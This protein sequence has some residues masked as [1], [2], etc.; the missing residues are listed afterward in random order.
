M[1][2]AAVPAMSLARARTQGWLL[3]ALIA[4]SPAVG[5]GHPEIALALMLGYVLGLAADWRVS[6][7]T[8]YVLFVA[9]VVLVPAQYRLGAR[10]PIDMRVD[11]LVLLM[12]LAGWAFGLFQTLPEILTPEAKRLRAPLLGLLGVA[13][14]SL[15]LNAP[16]GMSEGYLAADVKGLLLLGVFLATYFLTLKVVGRDDAERVAALAVVTGV[17]AACI[18]IV[19]R[20]AG[21][22]PVAVTLLTLPGVDRARPDMVLERGMQ[23]RVM[24]TGEHPI[25]FGAL[26]AML[27]PLAVYFALSARGARRLAYTGAAAAIAVAMLLSVSRSALLAGSVAFLVLLAVWPLQRRR[28]LSLAMAL[29]L[30]VTVAAP[31][32]LGTLGKTMRPGWIV[33]QE[34]ASPS[35]RM[36]D[37]PRVAAIVPRQPLFGLGW[38]AFD[39]ARY[40]YLDN[41][42]LKTLLE[43]GIAGLALAALFY[44][45]VTGMLWRAARESTA[46]LSLEGALLA[47]IAAFGVLSLL[48]DTFGF[49]QLVYV[50]FIFAALSVVLVSDAG[51]VRHAVVS[52]GEAEAS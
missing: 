50:F 34:K 19:E 44:A 22:N 5:F 7:R 1:T 2:P 10:L 40:F 30:L 24:G 47:A 6:P 46:P 45:R 31:G 27:L 29:L 13:A 51:A 36:E 38:G 8:L 41:Q 3:F 52:E 49:S 16:R 33:Q 23:L 11:R 26:M 15:I 28:L 32:L 25:A 9:A 42:V 48:F 43:V 18:A 4:V 39:A 14:L 17:A 20:F 35:S 37:Y 21:F 12:L